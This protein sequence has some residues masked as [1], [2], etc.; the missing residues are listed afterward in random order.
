[1]PPRKKKKTAR[2]QHQLAIDDPPEVR[3]FYP[4]DRDYLSKSC[5]D[6]LRVDKDLARF[7]VYSCEC[8]NVAANVGRKLFREKNHSYLENIVPSRCVESC[9]QSPCQP[10]V[11]SNQSIVSSL[12][13]RREDHLASAGA[14]R[15]WALRRSLKRRLLLG[16]PKKSLKRADRSKF[17]RRDLHL[18]FCQS[19]KL[20]PRREKLVR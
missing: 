17:Q 6:I 20:T 11:H 15:D 9:S 8:V 5:L 4:R 10:T 2:V 13:S 3:S 7:P 12:T 16:S 14:L 19:R 18:V 1:M